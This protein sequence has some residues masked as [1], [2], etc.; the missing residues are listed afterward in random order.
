MAELSSVPTESYEP[1]PLP[2]S[3]DSTL[4]GDM[5][6]HFQLVIVQVNR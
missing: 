2:K 6:E 1:T 5:P 4:L 3:F